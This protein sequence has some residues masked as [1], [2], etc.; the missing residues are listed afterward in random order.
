MILGLESR[1]M[2]RINTV[3]I[4]DMRTQC[5]IAFLDEEHRPESF[6]LLNVENINKSVWFKDII[7]EQ[8]VSKKS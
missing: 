7:A 8:S 1:Y 3:T 4:N 6:K 2:H 5:L